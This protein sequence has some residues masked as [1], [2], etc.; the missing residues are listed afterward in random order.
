MPLARRPAIVMNE[1]AQRTLAH[2]EESPLE[3]ISRMAHTTAPECYINLRGSGANYIYIYIE[4][5][6]LAIVRNTRPSI[7]PRGA[8]SLFAHT[9]HIF[10]RAM[11]RA[12]KFALK[13]AAAAAGESV[14]C[15]C[16]YT[17]VRKIAQIF[18]SS[19]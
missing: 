12:R 9:L 11:N 6:V 8:Q 18:F 4:S 17:Y 14:G 1:S 7:P 13:A 3:R 19:I 15:A 10:A 5:F 16:I 2:G